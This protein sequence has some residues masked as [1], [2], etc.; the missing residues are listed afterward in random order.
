MKL[1]FAKFSAIQYHLHHTVN[2]LSRWGSN[3]NL[4]K[5]TLAK[6]LT[7]IQNGIQ[8]DLKAGTSEASSTDYDRHFAFVIINLLPACQPVFYKT[9]LV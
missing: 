8:K 9:H 6:G 5:Q 1:C 7:F 2:D 4:L 3:D